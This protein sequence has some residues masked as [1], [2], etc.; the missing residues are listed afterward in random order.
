MTNS[1][2]NSEFFA[3]VRLSVG[4]ARRL[5]HILDP[6]AWIGDGY[7]HHNYESDF[8]HACDKLW[9]L[10]I[11]EAAYRD[12]LGLS[13]RAVPADPQNL[14]MF[15]PFFRFFAPLEI[16]RRLSLGLPESAPA[17][18]SLLASYLAI[19]TDYGRPQLS[20]G[21]EPFHPE[22]GCIRE[23]NTLIQL[24]YLER[25]NGCIGNFSFSD[26]H[27]ADYDRDRY[28][29]QGYNQRCVEAVKWTDK[30]A[31]AMTQAYLWPIAKQQI[32]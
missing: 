6:M 19:A 18:E 28:I 15:P 32:G 22:R 10:E 2:T 3:G 14:N 1:W 21:L 29:E 17:F 11:A 8:E 7:V 26:W 5:Y 16:E 31:V 30:V 24:G 9:A 13:L 23:V 27:E 20:Y 12:D 4:L 25:S